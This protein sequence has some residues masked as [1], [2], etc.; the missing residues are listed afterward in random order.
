[1]STLAGKRIVVGVSGGIAAYKSPDLVRRLRDAGAEVRVVM[2]AGASAFISPLTLQAVS[3]QRVHESLL[4]AEAEAG[5]GHIELARWADELIIAPA[6][7]HLI[8][9][10]AHGFAD[11]LLATLVLATESRVW[12]A[13]AMNRV[14]WDNAQ[15][16]ANC[17]RLEAMGMQLLGPGVGS[18]A[19]GEQGAGRMLEPEQI[20]AALG[21]REP[22][23]AGLHFMVTAGPT[24]EALDPVRFLGNRSSGRMGFAL[25]AAL[26]EAGAGVDLVSG[27]VDLATP[28]GVSRVDVESAEQMLVA[29]MAGIDQADGFIG[30]AAVADYRPEQVAEHK[31]KKNGQALELRLVPNPDILASVAALANRPR[32]VMGFAAETRDLAQ[33][34][35]LKLESKRLDLIAA[36]L[37]GAG[38]AFDC[39]DNALEVFSR[40]QHWP[41]AR[42]SKTAL[43]QQLVRI[44]A[45]QLKT[46]ETDQA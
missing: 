21:E 46:R 45:Q 33:A 11:D 40:D 13:P 6:T 36:N 5:M 19:C 24:H 37:V 12:L 27:P 22:L 35:R 20:V 39:D 15:V 8:A 31:I 34:A 18:Q 14:M 41:L 3:G 26:A 28:P 44:I 38:L 17:R 9:R 23:L 16:Q 2:T 25:A 32:L 43:A 10:L 42:Q 4:D 30:V 29:V 7:A 1:M